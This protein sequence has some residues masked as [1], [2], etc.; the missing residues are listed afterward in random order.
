MPTSL[1]ILAPVGNEACLDAALR[2]GADAVYFGLD[3][4]FNARARA[5]N[6][7]ASHLPDIMSKIHDYGRRGYLT[8][9][10]L[11]F[12]DE[13]SAVERLIE[14]AAR[15]G[16]DAAIVQ[17]FGVAR[18]VKRRVPTLRLHASTQI[19]CTD[20]SAVELLAQLGAERITLGREL[21]L[22]D[23]AQMATGSSV[24]LEMFVHGALC[25]AYSGQC[26]TSEAIGGRS[27]NRGACAQACRLP[28]DLVV[29][30]VTRDLGNV[31]YLLSPADLDASQRIPEIVAS[32]VRAIKIEG[33]LKSPD[34]VAATTRLYR[35]AVDAALDGRDA[36]LGA[37]RELS[38][39]A[40]SRGGSLGF[41]A[42]N[43]H[44][45]LVDGTTCD[46]IGLEVGLCLGVT[47]DQNRNWL[48]LRTTRQLATGDG[49][50]VQGQRA[51]Q[52]ELGGRI[53]EM[54]SYGRKLD[55]CEAVE[56]LWVWL[57]PERTIV[58]EFSGR[59]VFRTSSGAAK[60]DLAAA[61]PSEP[62]RIA[63][64]VRLS[65]AIGEHPQLAIVAADGRAVTVQLDQPLELAQRHAI[66][67]TTIHDKLARL[68]ET[69]YRLDNLELDIPDTS[70]LPISALN[71]ARRAAT[72]R[73]NAAARRSHA[74][75][76]A[77]D[78][79][80]DLPWPVKP[81]PPAGLWVTCRNREQAEAALAAG[82]QGIYLD[83][84]ALTGVGPMLRELRAR[85]NAAIGVALPR[86]RKPGEDKID[87]YVR[88]LEPDYVLIR[89]LG[90]LASTVDAGAQEPSNA[91]TPAWI[92]DFSLNV[93]N[94]W[95]ARELLSRPLAAFTPGYDLD[96][97][98][99][100]ALLEPRIAP[101]AEVVIHHPM[102]LFHMEH[103]VFAALL[104]N[105]HDHHDCG[106][107][108][109][110]HVVSLRDRTGVELP[111]EADIGCRNTV[112]HGIAQ[113]AADLVEV[114]K[115]QGVRR[116]RVELVR[117][118]PE[119]AAA[120]VR[121]H[122]ELLAGQLT[123]NHLRQR[124]STLGLRVVRGSLRVVG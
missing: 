90:S 80:A 124:L 75:V 23:I 22:R 14:C 5:E 81:P 117:E 95:T 98:Q 89:S 44:Q 123:A 43:D 11:V 17:D 39:Q 91:R 68:G 105:G 65:G 122:V 46:H 1:E 37:I 107:P 88:G 60:S 21:S 83:I 99:L 71:R 86:V 58:G 64:T 52:G 103:C 116:F 61:I 2:A 97:T 13:L 108:C 119:Q 40:F 110:R 92:G 47:R 73:L 72:T 42:G 109:E 100:V 55:A 9:N 96:A 69:H 29:D 26:L 79:E 35:L 115:R 16:V 93:A 56:E 31:A 78:I 34:Y 7:K 49:I 82:A 38:A 63:L 54:R 6:I 41:L 51:S 25:I 102:P 50:L 74:V 66:D 8:V 30:G 53:W 48:R 94:R 45:A 112:F 121:A 32:G 28:Y 118:T 36:P 70:I 15:A 120:L 77:F 85:S 113:S 27:A 62:E 87:G 19:T 20:R 4:G 101:Y 3:I 106:R 57:G 114:L 104:S 24:E 18:L 76:D 33:R 67:R 111:L 84:L 59:R 12:D 10:T